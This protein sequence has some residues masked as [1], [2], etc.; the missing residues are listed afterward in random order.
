MLL[1]QETTTVQL[2]KVALPRLGQINFVNCLPVV[3]PMEELQWRSQADI[4]Y[5]T[6][7]ELNQAFERNEL[8]IGAMSS[9]YFL[10]NGT[11][12]LIEGLSISSDGA[13]ASVMC[14]SKVPLNELNGAR[15]AVPAASA[16]SVNLLR[17]LLLEVFGAVPEVVDRQSPTIADAD[18]QAALVFGDQALYAE[19]NYGRR[20]V[21]ADLGEWWRINTGLP[22]VFGLWAAHTQWADANPT[23]FDRISAAL[24][25]AVREGLTTRFDTVVEEGCRRTGL[26]L[27]RIR[28][29]FTADLNY[30][31]T[32]RHLA[33]L[34]EYGTLC[35]KH[36][37]FN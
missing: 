21:R 33:G 7:Q 13:V 9:F 27:E 6:P 22:M 11:L 34:I 28:R 14:Y 31:L 19:E 26:S 32:D 8:D 17:V 18:V 29:Y 3:V 2:G 35:K 4:T 20:L 15:I 36:G 30:E 5:A 12:K 23:S 16:T 37:L 1:A 10:K 24:N 25:C